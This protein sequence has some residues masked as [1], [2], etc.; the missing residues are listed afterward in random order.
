MLGAPVPAR[1]TNKSVLQ[2]VEVQQTFCG[3]LNNFIFLSQCLGKIF[4]TFLAEQVLWCS[5]AVMM[6]FANMWRAAEPKEKSRE[7]SL[8]G[9]YFTKEV[10]IM[11]ILFGAN[12]GKIY[13]S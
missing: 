7:N 5:A 13:F 2:E 11:N 1:N 4:N 8:M 12:D 6:S 10:Q 3:K 9:I